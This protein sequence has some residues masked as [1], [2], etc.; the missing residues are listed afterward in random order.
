MNPDLHAGPDPD[1]D[2]VQALFGTLT[3]R[4]R[5]VAAYITQGTPNKIIAAELGISQRTIEAHRARIFLKLRVRNAVELTQRCLYWC[6]PAVAPAMTLAEPDSRVVVPA[7]FNASGKPVPGAKPARRW[8]LCQPG[9][10]VA[11]PAA[12]LARSGASPA[13]R[14][15]G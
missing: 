15:T 4:E 5:E 10:S 7:G 14:S 2:S 3:L 1:P 8:G 9:V 13:I 12:G 11:R 6:V